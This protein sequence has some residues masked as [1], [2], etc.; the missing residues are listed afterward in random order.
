MSQITI[1]DLTFSYD[2]T[3][4]NIFEHVSFQIDTD[5]KLG[6]IGR[7]GR[8]KTTFLNL[9]L[10]KYE[11]QGTI[12][13]SVNFDYFPFEV[14]DP[15]TDTL[16]IIK[17]TIAPFMQWEREMEQC[18]L[19]QAIEQKELKI[20]ATTKN[21]IEPKERIPVKEPEETI[22]R[23]TM[24]RYGILLDLY[25][26]HDG[27][28][29]E[30]LI[31]KELGKLQVDLSVLSRPFST[32]SFGERTK[33]MLAALFLKKNNFLLIDEPTNHLD[34][35]GRETLANYLQTKKGF[36]LVSH[37]RAFLDQCIDHVLSIN[38]AD[39]EVQKGNYTTWQQNK[40]LQDNYEL[41]KN[42][43]LKKDITVLAEAAKR[44]TGWSDQVEASK[45]GSHAADRG[46]IG[47]KAAKM[48][49]RAKSIENRKLDA[50]EEKKGLLKNIEQADALRMNL[51]PFPK[52]RLMEVE[53]LNLFYG[54][55]E[56][57]SAINF[58][59]L[60][61]DRIAIRGKN[62]SGKSTLYRLLLGDEIKFTGRFHVAQGLKV[63][64]VSQDT[65]HLAGNLKDFAV[66]NGLDEAIFKTVLRQLDFSRGQF[67]KEIQDFS[68]GQKKK[69]LLAKSLSEPANVFLWDEPLNFVDV[70][71]R[72]QV[73][74]LILKYQPTMIFVEHDRLFA[75]K[76]A[77]KIVHLT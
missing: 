23:P 20:E 12:N 43:Q 11:Y 48:M 42:E 30:E 16:D 44:A 68:G 38:R 4:D 40:E 8:G 10:G 52:K 58:T 17:N 59:L 35:E 27:Y 15:S 29:I 56:I 3:Y 36:I 1:N 28:I 33:I 46:A 19:E 66:T 13:A 22:V 31:E 75:D 55:R 67:E 41:A 61:G 26:A 60:E 57:A 69:V 34:M 45:I 70:F 51:L 73:E 2:T 53:N 14:I 18:L 65:S 25:Q 9:L 63:S 76:I 6:F 74:E 49:K 54:E 50:I 21:E 32:L 72:V 64:Y 62:G 39:I 24:E 71:S 5:W 47:H 77:T 7:N 37:D